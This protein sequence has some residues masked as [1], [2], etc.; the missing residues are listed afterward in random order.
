MAIDRTETYIKV[1]NLYFL[2]WYPDVSDSKTS[3]VSVAGFSSNQLA[4]YKR[5]ENLTPLTNISACKMK[6]T[7]PEIRRIRIYRRRRNL[8]TRKY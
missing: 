2:L 8:L 5:Q 3:D 7:L 4:I 6:Q 1:K